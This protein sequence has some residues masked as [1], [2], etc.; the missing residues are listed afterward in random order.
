LHQTI[1]RASLL[2]KA[3]HNNVVRLM[4]KGKKMIEIKGSSSEIGEVV[5]DLSVQ[6]IEG[7]DL[8]ISFSSKYMMDALRAME[9][10]E[11]NIEFT[12]S[13]RPFIL[14]PQNE[15]PIIQLILPVRTY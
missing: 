1:D 11:V 13:M 10:D 2:A 3:E 4:T 7:E 8:K 14:H 12:G 6:S 15:D 9:V 5:E